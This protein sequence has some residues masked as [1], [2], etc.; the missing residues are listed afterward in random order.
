MNTDKLKELALFALNAAQMA[1]ANAPAFQ[2]LAKRVGTAV[3]GA[4]EAELNT[5]LDAAVKGRKAA[6]Q[7]MQDAGKAR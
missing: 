1:G 7:G 3:G 5:A 4:T 2:A 6:H